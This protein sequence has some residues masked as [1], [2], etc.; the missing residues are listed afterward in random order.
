MGELRKFYC[1]N[2]ETEKPAYM[3]HTGDLLEYFC[4]DCNLCLY[5]EKDGSVSTDQLPEE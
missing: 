2:C 5:C 1:L 3:K 4:C